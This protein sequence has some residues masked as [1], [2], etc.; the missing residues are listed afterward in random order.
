MIQPTWDQLAESTH[1]QV[2]N[3]KHPEGSN[4]YYTKRS[5][6]VDGG[7]Y[8]V[9][10]RHTGKI[11]SHHKRYITRD[12]EIGAGQAARD[13]NNEDKGKGTDDERPQAGAIAQAQGLKG[14]RKV[15]ASYQ[16]RPY[17][18]TL[19]EQVNPMSP[20]RGGTPK[21][22]GFSVPQLSGAGI[23]DMPTLKRHGQIIGARVLGADKPMPDGYSPPEW[24]KFFT[25]IGLGSDSP[26]S[27]GNMIGNLLEQIF[28]PN[29]FTVFTQNANTFPYNWRIW[30]ENAFQPVGDGPPYSSYLFQAGMG[31]NTVLYIN[32][33]A[34]I[35]AWIPMMV[36]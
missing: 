30:S 29:W 11:V 14:M 8:D 35:G 32:W 6:H 21:Q 18:R 33:D 23:K 19:N 3:E 13:L 7:G 24:K 1:C 10:D 12:G 2:L 26:G 36:Y 5:K 4:R 15:N 9:I 17:P 28:G 27:E 25:G 31:S 22:T 34:E 16:H 20:T